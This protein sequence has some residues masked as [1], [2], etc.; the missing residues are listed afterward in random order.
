M[1]LPRCGFPDLLEESANFAA[2]GNKWNKSDLT[3]KFVK[4]TSDLSEDEVRTAIATAFSLLGAVTPLTFTEATTNQADILISFV[5]GEHGDNNP[6]DGTGNGLAHA[7]FPPPNS[8]DLAGEGDAHFDDSEAWSV[9]LS[10]SGIDLVT[11]AAHEFGHSL[12]LSHSNVQ[13]ALMFPSYSGPH[14]SL[15]Q[16][17]KVGIQSIYGPNA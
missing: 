8:G 16:D 5:T 10:S 12:G 14:R 15:H 13:G 1:K 7:Y 17:D 2:Q 6:F 11:V 3:Y 9:N 4:F